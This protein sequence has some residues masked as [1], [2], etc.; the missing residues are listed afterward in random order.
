VRIV[1]PTQRLAARGREIRGVDPQ[2]ERAT[3]IH[4][5]RLHAVHA[6]ASLDRDATARF[7][8]AGIDTRSVRVS[9]KF[10]QS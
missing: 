7:P 1:I 10:A 3:P 4:V 6:R 2:I 9:A 5:R 8:D